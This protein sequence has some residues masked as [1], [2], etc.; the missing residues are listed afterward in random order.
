SK[1]ISNWI[2]Y[3]FYDQD[4]INERMN[5]NERST[6]QPPQNVSWEGD[7]YSKVLGNEKRG[8]VRGLGLGPIPSVLWGSKSSVEN[9]VLE[10]SSNKVVQ[11]LEQEITELEEKQNEEIDLMKQNQK[12]S[13]SKLLQIRQFMQKYA[14]NESLL[15]DIIGTSNEQ[16]PGHNS[17]LEGVPQ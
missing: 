11:R 8:Y 12:K 14:P 10:D 16:V 2:Y 6:D 1:R 17:G 13:Q 9:I 3:V 7:M 4:M 5:N 15:Q